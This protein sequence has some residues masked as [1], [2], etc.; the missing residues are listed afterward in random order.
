[1]NLNNIYKFPVIEQ[2]KLKPLDEV[3]NDYYYELINRI[4]PKK[5]KYKYF[6]YGLHIFH[7]LF[8]ILFIYIGIAL[9][10]KL[11][12]YVVLWYIFVMS[13]WLILGDC[14]FTIV[15]NHIAGV[16]NLQ[17]FPINIRKLYSFIL[18]LTVISLFFY[19]CPSFSLYNFLV[20][21]DKITK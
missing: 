20:Y 10:P 14:W 12:I 6:V 15:T 16:K 5:S 21:I 7:I 19:L 4:Y 9:P 11:Q 13:S 17:L 2:N 1:M 18:I 8:T 3:I